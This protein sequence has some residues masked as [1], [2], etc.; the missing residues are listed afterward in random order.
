MLHLPCCFTLGRPQGCPGSPSS[1]ALWHYLL[2]EWMGASRWVFT[3]QLLCTHSVAPQLHSTAISEHSGFSHFSFRGVCKLVQYEAVRVWR[4]Q[5]ANELV[6]SPQKMAVPLD[7]FIL[8]VPRHCF[9]PF[10]Y[11]SLPNFPSFLHINP[12]CKR[13]LVKHAFLIA[14]I[15]LHVGKLNTYVRSRSSC[16]QQLHHNEAHDHHPT[17]GHLHHGSQQRQRKA[18]SQSSPID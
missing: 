18:V 11:L 10:C 1:K 2:L 5:M 12:I 8:A 3:V 16:L 15:L 7:T 14:R 13:L 6:S 4:P 9:T 17:H